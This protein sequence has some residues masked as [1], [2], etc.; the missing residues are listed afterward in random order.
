MP[1]RPW[2]RGRADHASRAFAA[3]GRVVDERADGPWADG[4]PAER[5]IDTAFTHASTYKPP[6]PEKRLM[7]SS[8]RRI[9]ARRDVP[10]RRTRTQLTP[11][12]G[13]NWTFL[14]LARCIERG[15]RL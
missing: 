10:T 13:G 15:D 3:I 5:H 14:A 9:A 6:R 11:S 12:F 2:I 1:A 7:G 8:R 4:T